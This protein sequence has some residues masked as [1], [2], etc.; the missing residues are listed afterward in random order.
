MLLAWLVATSVNDH[1][2]ELDRARRGLGSTT[3]VWVA[4]GDIER[5]ATV[6]A[7]R[8]SVPVAFV[9]ASAITVFE[10]NSVARQS[11]SLGEFI[12]AD[13]I[14]GD[15]TQLVPDGWVVVAVVESPSSGTDR[16]DSVSVASGGFVIADDAVVIESASDRTLVAVPAAVGP[17]V[18]TANQQHDIALL[19]VIGG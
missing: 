1:I 6:T 14:A 17:L 18:A 16:G 12:V 3:E 15:P 19:R 2:S 5:G 8:R 7:E 10:P 9:P 4:T 13:D 11:I